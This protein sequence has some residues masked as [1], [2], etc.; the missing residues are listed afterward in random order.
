MKAING[1]QFRKGKSGNPAGKPK[2]TQN[3]AT[4]DLRTWINILINKNLPKIEKD[5]ESLD[6]K[7]RL[8]VIERLIQYCIPKQQAISVEAQIQAE[9]SELEKLIEKMPDAAVEQIT[10]RLIKLNQLNAKQ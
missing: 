10:Q 5:L 6:S 7:D 8:Q 3:K 9:Y 1:G 4:T 2:G